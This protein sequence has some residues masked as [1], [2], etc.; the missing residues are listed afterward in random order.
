MSEG[1]HTIGKFAM[2]ARF[3]S[4]CKR[5]N[6]RANE[7]QERE[8]IQEEMHVLVGTLVGRFLNKGQIDN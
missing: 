1:H 7:R 6:E 8:I 5:R 3:S 2:S 4:G